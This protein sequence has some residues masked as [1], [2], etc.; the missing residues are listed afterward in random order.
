M[1]INPEIFS[2]IDH[3]TPAQRE[4]AAKILYRI[5]Y[6]YKNWLGMKDATQAGHIGVFNAYKRYGEAFIPF[7]AVGYIKKQLQIESARMQR[8]VDSR[9]KSNYLDILIIDSPDISP[10]S[11]DF[12]RDVK[13]I[14]TD[15]EYD[16]FLRVVFLEQDIGKQLK[17]QKLYA[18]ALQ[19]L[20][21]ELYV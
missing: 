19:K 21:E 3:W 10:D 8:F 16:L 1:I 6:R 12:L 5:C 4:T 17:E 2:Y 13:N 7:K 20:K 9:E 11:I 14:L 15:L 18:S